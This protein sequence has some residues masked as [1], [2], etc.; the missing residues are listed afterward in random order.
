[1]AGGLEIDLLVDPDRHSKT[2][3]QAALPEEGN[4]DESQILASE[5]TQL[6][7]IDVPHLRRRRAVEY[8]NEGLGRGAVRQ[9]RAIVF[10]VRLG[11]GCAGHARCVQSLV[12]DHVVVTDQ[13]AGGLVVEI[14]SLP[15]D[16]GMQLGD[17]PGSGK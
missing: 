15:P 4:D 7:R 9:E 12:R 2:G 8:R 6:I 3:D 1:M 14:E 10:R 11:L 17:L 5:D 13:R 16:L